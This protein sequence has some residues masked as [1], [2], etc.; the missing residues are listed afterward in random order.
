MYLPVILEHNFP[1]L[2]E[3]CRYS[4]FFWSIFSHI[5]TEYGDSPYSVEMRENTD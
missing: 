2:R 4:E 1:A 5:W 3:K